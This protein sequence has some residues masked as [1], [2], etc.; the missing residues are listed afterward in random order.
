MGDL[1]NLTVGE[2]QFSIGQTLPSTAIA[3]QIMRYSNGKWS[4]VTFGVVPSG[5][6]RAGLVLD[7]Y[8]APSNG[9]FNFGISG[10]GGVVGGTYLNQSFS[11]AGQNK[12]KELATAAPLAGLDTSQGGTVTASDTVLSAIGK[13]AA[14]GGGGGSTMIEGEYTIPE[15]YW[16]TNTG[17]K[18]DNNAI[19]GLNVK[20]WYQKTGKFVRAAIVFGINEVQSTSAYK[21]S[22]GFNRADLFGDGKLFPENAEL[23]FFK[24]SAY[25]RILPQQ[26]ITNL[27]RE[28]YFFLSVPTTSGAGYVDLYIEGASN[29]ASFPSTNAGDMNRIAIE[30]VCL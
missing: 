29:I 20:V 26:S 8:G 28:P 4:P 27:Y 1:T 21:Q 22:F 19:A 17:L 6:A 5:N 23:V 13:L 11:L 24:F 30:A 15:V 16:C 25:G 10:P 18:A 2:E 9:N 14:S 3:G 12:I 7:N